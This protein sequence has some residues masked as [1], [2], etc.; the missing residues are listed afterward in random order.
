LNHCDGATALDGRR[1]DHGGGAEKLDEA[2][3]VG[4]GRVG[5]A[6]TVALAG[7]GRR[8]F[9]VDSNA[10]Q[11]ADV[12][13]R[14]IDDP[15]IQARLADALPKI[16]LSSTPRPSRLHIVCV[17]TSWSSSAGR[18]ADLA[19]LSRAAEE[20]GAVLRAGDTVVL[21]S[22][23]PAGTARQ[24]LLPILERVSGLPSGPAGFG[25]AVAPERRAG[26]RS[27]TDILGLPQI[28]GGLDQDSTEAAALL[29]ERVAPSIVDAGSLE[30]AELIKLACNAYQDVISGFTNELAAM[31]ADFNVDVRKAIAAANVD[32]SGECIPMPSPG[33]WGP[34]LTKD[35]LFLPGPDGDAA[36]RHSVIR[37][38]RLIKAKAPARLAGSVLRELSVSGR[39][40]SDAQVLVLGVA[41][42]GASPIAGWRGSPT[43]DVVRELSGKVATVSCHDPVVPVESLLE[44]GL[45]PAEWPASRTFDAIVVMTDA[46]CYLELAATTWRRLA[47][48][49]AV[50]CDP[51]G[52]L[53]PGELL[54]PK[55]FRV[56]LGLSHRLEAP[57]E[58]LASRAS[59][60]AV[61]RPSGDTG[62]GRRS[63]LC[64][65]DAEPSVSTH[66]SVLGDVCCASCR[67]QEAF[68]NVLRDG[69]YDGV[70]IR[71]GLSFTETEFRLS[72]GLRWIATP[73]T[74]TDH[75]DLLAAQARMVEVI[76]LRDETDWLRSITPTAEHTWTLLLALERK[77]VAACR[78]VA[79]GGWR[80][81]PFLGQELAGRTL[82]VL[83][84]GRLGRVVAGYGTAFGMRVLAH[85]I[86]DTAD[87]PGQVEAVSFE[88]LLRSA[89]I[90][91]VHLPLSPSTAGLVNEEALSLMKP[92]AR[93]VNTSRGQIVDTRALL[94]ALDSGHLGGAALDVV[95]DDSRW[96][97]RSPEHNEAIGYARQH[98][99]LLITPHIGGYAQPAVAR[100]RIHLAKKIL[101]MMSTD[102]R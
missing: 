43:L 63:I 35:P 45:R 95:D 1:L 93:L 51:W 58:R 39:S 71:L 25:L 21:R 18:P 60:A 27:V 19:N 6:L 87:R 48:P 86:A 16:T 32:Y 29:F 5:L 42:K 74:G 59:M 80:R 91:S 44:E 24:F 40:I 68:R 89:D 102:H 69:S 66:L 37:S 12:R 4:L 7:R 26:G 30:A 84:Y 88:D 73:T 83:G 55:G 50:L 11:L 28:V 75:I 82:G 61:T 36:H 31:A 99:N 47:A 94:L 54:G 23:A 20:I 49:G 10:A 97:E 15:D 101:A 46:L 41:F 72:P 67:T 65:D 90:L 100:T 33:V 85:D 57:E 98:T 14:R 9:G 52:L 92:G 62:S 13:E 56:Y 22:T 70:L 17:D 77:M 3:V 34:C 38:A 76:S 81:N 78:D 53:P 8:L 96:Y 79:R 2:Q 64:V